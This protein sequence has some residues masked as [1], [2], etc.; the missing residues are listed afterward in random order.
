MNAISPQTNSSPPKPR[1]WKMFVASTGKPYARSM[2]GCKSVMA[3]PKAMPR[4]PAVMLRV[5]KFMVA[6]GGLGAPIVGPM[7]RAAILRIVDWTC[8][9]LRR[10]ST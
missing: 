10:R 3:P 2:N 7:H 5:R 6:P 4:T 8:A 1:A 9:P